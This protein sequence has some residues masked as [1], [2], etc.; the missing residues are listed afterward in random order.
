MDS[1]RD[2]AAKYLEDL[3]SFFGLNVTVES[4][5]EGQTIELM[6]PSTHLNGFLI[7]QRG[8][9]LRAL[10]HLTNMALKRS[11]YE[12]VLVSIDVAG[13]RKQK[14]EQLTKRVKEIAKEV[15]TNGEERALEPM[16]A[17]ERRVTHQVVSEQE[18]LTTESLGEG[19]D[20]HVVIKKA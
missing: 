4:T 13:Y 10:Q 2:T 12:D 7:G 15:Q 3:L 9:T 1:A 16:S 11:G 19:R 18:G 20:R 6:V 5:E 14:T 17:Y 8:D